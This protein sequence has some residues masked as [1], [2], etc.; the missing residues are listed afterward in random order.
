[1]SKVQIKASLKKQDCGAAAT[2]SVTHASPLIVPCAILRDSILHPAG[3]GLRAAP[4]ILE[5]ILLLIEKAN[6]QKT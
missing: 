5:F 6:H 4:F 1:M 2:Q 3:G